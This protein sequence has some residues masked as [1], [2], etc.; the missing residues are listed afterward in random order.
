MQQSLLPWLVPLIF[1]T[2]SA[3]AGQKPDTDGSVEDE[4]DAQ[5]IE[6]LRTAALAKIDVDAC[7]AGGGEVRQEGMLGLPRC[8]TPYAD[9]GKKCRDSEECLG[10]CLGDDAET[11]YEAAP[12]E[13]TGLCEADDSP[14]GCNGEINDGNYGGFICVD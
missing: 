7:T 3:C 2:L 4:G 10:R 8:V 12:G 14:F 5:S 6:E 11:D 13:M 1:L 9:A